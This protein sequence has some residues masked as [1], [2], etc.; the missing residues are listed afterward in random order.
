MTKKCS[1]EDSWEKLQ[2]CVEYFW[3]NE[4]TRV[5]VGKDG[6]FEV[7][8]VIDENIA[9]GNTPNYQAH[10]KNEISQNCSGY[11]FGGRPSDAELKGD[12]SREEAEELIRTGKAVY[13]NGCLFNP[14]TGEQIEYPPLYESKPRNV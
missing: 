2:R 4:N 9:G 14:E 3:I 8:T 13:V 7:T 11:M 6:S 10:R 5:G 12:I 1:K